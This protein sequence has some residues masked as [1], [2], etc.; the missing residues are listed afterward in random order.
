MSRWTVE[1]EGGGYEEFDAPS[2]REARRQAVRAHPYGR[3]GHGILEVRPFAAKPR[4]EQPPDMPSLTVKPNPFE[5]LRS[6]LP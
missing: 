3:P 5:K 6:L 4:R 2:E 1:Y